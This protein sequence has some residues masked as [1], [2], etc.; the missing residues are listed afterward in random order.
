MSDVTLVR[1]LY[2]DLSPD[3]DGDYLFDDATIEAW[4]ELSHGN[5]FRAAAIACRALAADQNYLLK[6]VRTDDLAVNGPAVAAEFRQLAEKLDDRAD[7]ED[8][9]DDNSFAIVSFQRNCPRRPEATIW[10][11]GGWGCA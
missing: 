8:A 3:S 10:P 11:V 5:P 4:L 9:N 1:S 2:G 6:H 7:E